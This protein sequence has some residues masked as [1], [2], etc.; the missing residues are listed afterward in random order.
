LNDEG[1][2]DGVDDD[3]QMKMAL[4]MSMI[5]QASKGGVMGSSTTNVGAGAGGA[6]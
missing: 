6:S 2:V 5:G 4:R 3:E 1:D